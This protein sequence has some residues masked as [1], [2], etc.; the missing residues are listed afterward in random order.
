[1][2]RLFLAASIAATL[3]TS[4]LPQP[5]PADSI[6]QGLKLRNNWTCQH[7]RPLRRRGGG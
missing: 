6:F 7:E 5:N 2:P 3:V 1:M 4:L